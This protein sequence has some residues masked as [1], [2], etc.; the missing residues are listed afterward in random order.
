MNEEIVINDDGI[1]QIPLKSYTQS[2][3]LNYSMYVINDRALPNL[4]DGLKPVQ[5]RIIYAMSELGLK[6]SAKF[7]NLR[8]PLATSSANSI[9]TAI[10]PATRRWC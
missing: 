4:G 9:P 2:A 3:Y 8:A 7:K 1:E 5:R 6:A 10:P